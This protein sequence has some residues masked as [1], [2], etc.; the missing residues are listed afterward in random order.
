MR[1]G[2][3]LRFGYPNDFVEIKNGASRVRKGSKGIINIQGEIEFIVETVRT[4]CDPS[5]VGVSEVSSS[6]LYSNRSKIG[7]LPTAFSFGGGIELCPYNYIMTLLD[8]FTKKRTAQLQKHG[9]GALIFLTLK[10]DAEKIDATHETLLEMCNKLYPKK[11]E[12]VEVLPPIPSDE[13][14]LMRCGRVTPEDSGRMLQIFEDSGTPIVMDEDGDAMIDMTTVSSAGKRRLNE[15]LP[16]EGLCFDEE[17]EL[18]NNLSSDSFFETDKRQKTVADLEEYEDVTK[19]TGSAKFDSL[20]HASNAAYVTLG[21][22]ARELNALSSLP[23]E[24]EELCITISTQETAYRIAETSFRSTMFCN[25]PASLPDMQG[26]LEKLANDAKYIE[27]C[28]LKRAEIA[29]KVDELRE[30]QHTLCFE[31]EQ[32]LQTIERCHREAVNYQ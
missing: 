25:F 29:P 17:E 10:I 13:S 11:A 9:N 12:P 27:T 2:N 28:K 16:S 4:L 7:F 1:G 14:L 19:L 26:A 18:Q 3:R 30:L 23:K 31:R 32:A 15:E 5:M 22:I 24:Y 21:K 6:L 20:R 8:E